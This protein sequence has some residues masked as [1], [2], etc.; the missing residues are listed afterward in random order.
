[1][2]TMGALHRGHL[3]LVEQA[4]NEN[5]CVVVSIFVNPTQ[6]D[7]S[8]DLENYPRT[9][10][11]DLNLLK[12]TSENIIVFSPQAS[13]LYKNNITSKSFVFWNRK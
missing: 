11:S 6:F 12:S 3:A 4:L 13:E 9:L 2:P 5:E 8:Q 7:K 1:M 10:E